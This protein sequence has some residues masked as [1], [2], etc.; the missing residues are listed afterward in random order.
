MEPQ[1]STP[2]VLPQ[3]IVQPHS[4]RRLKILLLV[5]LFLLLGIVLIFAFQSYTNDMIVA[6]T[7]DETV[8]WKTYRNDEYGFEFM[9]PAGWKVSGDRGSNPVPIEDA[10][11]PE[12][13]S[14]LIVRGEDST[15][16][17]YNME[18][19]IE[20]NQEGLTP[21]QYLSLKVQDSILN[22]W[23]DTNINGYSAIRSFSETATFYSIGNDR[24][25]INLKLPSRQ[26]IESDQI[27]SSFRFVEEENINACQLIPEAGAC[28]ALFPS[29]YFDE[30]AGV[31]KETVW[32]GCG[33]VR[34][35]TTMEA[36][37]AQ[38]EQAR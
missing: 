9:Y 32:G 8:E 20:N 15:D 17:F 6:P 35:F 34:P 27:L 12:T 22:L 16:N 37:Q 11:N 10:P 28:L 5:L 24:Y 3:P 14:V 18:V 4:N 38:C 7:P 36:C 2:I 19:S 1:Q 33:G 13:H 26:A 30:E 29:F 21:R 23:E 31:C 25:V